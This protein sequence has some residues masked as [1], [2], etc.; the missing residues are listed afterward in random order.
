MYGRPYWA[1]GWRSGGA[2]FWPAALI[3]LGVYFLLSNLGLLWWLRGDVVWPVL[4]ILF[5]V[6]L[7]VGRGRW[8]R[9]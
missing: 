1:G 5:G 6:A 4:L 9:W 8:W 3:V 7:I 2:F